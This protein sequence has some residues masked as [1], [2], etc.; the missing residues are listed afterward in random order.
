MGIFTEAFRLVLALRVTS[1]RRRKKATFPLTKAA[2][3]E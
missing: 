2:T 1:L 3:A